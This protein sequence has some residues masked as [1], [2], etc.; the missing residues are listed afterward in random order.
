VAAGPIAETL[1][2]EGLSATFGLA[3]RVRATGGRWAVRAA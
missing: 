1:D 2:D 3:L